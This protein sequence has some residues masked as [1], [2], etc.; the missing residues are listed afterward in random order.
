MR[1]VAMRSRLCKIPLLEIQCQPESTKDAGGVRAAEKYQMCKRKSS[2]LVGGKMKNKSWWIWDMMV[3]SWMFIGI[4]Y[5]LNPVLVA[6]GVV[7]GQAVKV[8]IYSEI[9]LFILDMVIIIIIY[10]R[11]RLSDKRDL[12]GG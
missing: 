11:N 3:I 9:L 8:F 4:C 5:I 1:L 12:K 10:R 6:L 2:V 7:G